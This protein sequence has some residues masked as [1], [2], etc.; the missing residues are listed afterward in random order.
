[1]NRST[2][3]RLG[4][5]ELM[6]LWAQTPATPMNI[7][8]LGLLPAVP[9]LDSAGQLP[10]PALRTAIAARLDQTPALRRRIRRTRFGQGRPVWVDDDAFDLAGH[11]HAVHLPG[12]DP[13]GLLSWAATRAATPLDDRH[14]LWR[15]TFVTGLDTGEVGLLLVLHH[16]I[17]DGIAGVALATALLDAE[18]GER[19]AP[20]ACAPAPP[21]TAR[22]LVRDAAAGRLRALARLAA[23]PHRAL[24]LGR[25][26][27]TARTALAHPAP[28]LPLPVP[29][30]TQRR[31][32][33]LR[34][35]LAELRDSAHR[36]RV[37]IND[38]MLTAVAAGMRSLLD[39]RGV[40]VADLTLR[41]SVPVAA[42]A[43]SSNAGGTLPMLVGLPVGDPDPVSALR[44]VSRI[45][46]EAKAG[47]DRTDP[48][49]AH[50][51]L[52]PLFAVRLGIRWLRRHGG[53]RINL[54]LTNVPGPAHPLWLRGAPLAAAYPIAPVAAGVPIAAAVLSYHDVLCLTVNA[55]PRL[56]LGPFARAAGR[57]IEQLTGTADTVAG[58]SP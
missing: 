58:R 32:V 35:P 21:P 24:G 4:T 12:I 50:A 10:L 39:E 55:D 31:A 20:A 47:R 6:T 30:S 29:R 25:D 26:L 42:P 44:R 33:A 37:T 11:V 46:R 22:A 54:Y 34:W 57:A 13:D 36:H 2:W 14:P 45:S 43:G 51:P 18:A 27:R 49:P 8:M 1:M 19:P 38:L 17:A 28:Q 15:L 52:M 7:A 23:Q 56:D 40:P 48:G 3:Q 9:L 53:S 16:A 5:G 41:V